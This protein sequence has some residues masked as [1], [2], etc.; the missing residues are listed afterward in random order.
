MRTCATNCSRHGECDAQG[1]CLC[2]NGWT[3]EAC[4]GDK[5]WNPAWFVAAASDDSQWMIEA[6]IPL[7][8]IFHRAPTERDVWA[9]GL[10]RTVPLVGFQS[11]TQPAAISPRGE[12]FG[13]LMFE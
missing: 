1:V 11:W 12:G 8:E 13:F 5:T 7:G 3:G 4:A 10:Q 6:A 2:D 9:I